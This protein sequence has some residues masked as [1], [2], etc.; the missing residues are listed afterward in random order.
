[1]ERE[2]QRWVLSFL[3]WDGGCAPPAGGRKESRQVSQLGQSWWE[4]RVAGPRMAEGLRTVSA[5]REARAASPGVPGAGILVQEP[6]E[7]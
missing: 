7:F 4:M 2:A 6:R 1:M 5:S 3:H